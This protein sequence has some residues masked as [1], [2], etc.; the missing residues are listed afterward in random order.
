MAVNLDRPH[1]TCLILRFRYHSHRPT[2][3]AVGK[4]VQN[5]CISF[6]IRNI[7]PDSP[8]HHALRIPATAEG[9]YWQH[10]SPSCRPSSVPALQPHTHNPSPVPF[11]YT[12]SRPS[13]VRGSSC[14]LRYRKPRSHRSLC[15]SKAAIKESSNNSYAHHILF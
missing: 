7:S 12:H 3:C 15:R 14:Y 1:K 13:W 11:F 9:S 8:Q 2:D 10:H 4:T 5:I 6:S